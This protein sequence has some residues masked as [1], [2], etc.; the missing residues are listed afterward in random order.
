LHFPEHFFV[1]SD[2]A[3]A[4]AGAG[5][6]PS[7]SLSPLLEASTARSFL[8]WSFCGLAAAGRLG[9]LL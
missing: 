3:A 4:G 8:R 5:A 9:A 1:C 2:A 6:S 7:P